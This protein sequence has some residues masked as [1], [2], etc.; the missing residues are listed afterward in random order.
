MTACYYL[1]TGSTGLLGRYLL[2]D[3]LREGKRVA[4]LARPTEHE[5]ACQ[6]VEAVMGHWES[7]AGYGH[8]R[9]IVLE[10]DIC[11][12]GLGLDR[13]SFEWV[14]AHCRA[15]VHRAASITFA[16]INAA[17]PKRPTCEECTVCWSSAERRGSV[18]FTHAYSTAYI[19]RVSR[20]AGA[21]SE[22]DLGQ[23]L[24][25]VY[26]KS[27]LEAELLR[28]ADFLDV[29]TVY[30]PGE[31]G[32]RLAN[33]LYEQ[34]PWILRAAATGL[35]DGRQG[36]S[37]RDGPAVLQATAVG[38]ERAEELRSGRL[39]LAAMA[40]CSIARSITAA[41]IIWPRRKE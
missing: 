3:L 17:S 16:R 2:R 38:R 23:P 29:V 9:S 19:Y 24:G 20:R 37:G 8:G 4:V 1:L 14:A 36:S 5:T 39:G 41:R 26:E 33:R 10:G 6:H 40:I 18:S 12:P 34:L 35:C 27:K 11:R 30:R 7:V 22:L 28:A 31:P 32:R 13:A 25:N 15:V 21:Q